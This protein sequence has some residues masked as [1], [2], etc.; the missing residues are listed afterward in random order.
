[1]RA[2]V[3]A[4]VRVSAL[5]PCSRWSHRGVPAGGWEEQLCA[6]TRLV[7]CSLEAGPEGQGDEGAEKCNSEVKKEI[8]LS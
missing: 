1:M 2:A 8:V 4:A 5:G 6:E 3:A 7:P